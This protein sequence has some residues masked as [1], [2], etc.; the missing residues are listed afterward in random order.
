MS[1]YDPDEGPS[2]TGWRVQRWESSRQ[3]VVLHQIFGNPT[4]SFGG[5]APMQTVWQ[6]KVNKSIPPTSDFKSQQTPVTGSI[7]ERNTS[8]S[9]VEKCIRV[10]FD[11]FDLPSDVR[12]LAQISYSAHGGEIAVAFLRGGVTSFRV[13][14]LLLLITTR[15]M[16][17]LQ[18]LL[19]HSHLQAVVQLLFG[20][21]PTRTELC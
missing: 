6:T 12:T 10:S 21:I 20:M 16:L 19:L 5:Q 1:P 11:P 8:D 14:T 18:L 4:S 13:Q 17:A 7:S 3:P 15:L 9:S 2:I